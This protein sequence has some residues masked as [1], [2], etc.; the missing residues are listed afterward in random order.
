MLLRA[1]PADVQDRDGAPLLLKAS[2]Q[3][4]LFAERV[5]ADAVYAGDRV[6]NATSITV[7]VVRKPKDQVDYAVHSRRWVVERTFA[8]LG[9]NP[10]LTRDFEATIASANAFLYAASVILLTRRLA[11]SA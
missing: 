1:H 5:F 11:R 8:W 9:R 3:R 4:F 7:Q 6:A 10:R 2:R